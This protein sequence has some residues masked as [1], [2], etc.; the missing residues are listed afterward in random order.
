MI[1][2]LADTF[3]RFPVVVLQRGQTADQLPKDV[4]RT[5]IVGWEQA[6]DFL[7]EDFLSLDAERRNTATSLA[8]VLSERG[9]DCAVEAIERAIRHRRGDQDSEFYDFPGGVRICDNADVEAEI[10]ELIN[11]AVSSELWVR[12]PAEVQRVISRSAVIRG[13]ADLLREI[14]ERAGAEQVYAFQLLATHL[15]ARARLIKAHQTSQRD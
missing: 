10:A 12:P 9:N 11:L 4:G 1:S 8:L 2:G 13:A 3:N 15:Q 7:T 6:V 14:E 5:I